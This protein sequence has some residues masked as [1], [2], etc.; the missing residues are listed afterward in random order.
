MSN[1]LEIYRMLK[2]KGLI[3]N[4]I[5][6]YEEMLMKEQHDKDFRN[7]YAGLPK[8]EQEDFDFIFNK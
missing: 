8:K 4:E 2:E 1:L 5:P 6:E 3:I 7:W